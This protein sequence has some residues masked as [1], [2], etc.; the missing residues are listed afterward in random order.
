MVA[1]LNAAGLD[2]ATFG[3]HEFDF[4][5]KFRERMKESRF[6]Y[7]IANVFEKT[8]GALRGATY[9]IASWAACECRL[10]LAA[11]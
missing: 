5:P 7:T 4:G 9:I 2:I 3:N 1:A 6:A 11:G 10:W 8:E